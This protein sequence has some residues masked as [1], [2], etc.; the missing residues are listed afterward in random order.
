MAMPKRTPDRVVPNGSLAGAAPES[1]EGPA[2]IGVRTR[3]M[4]DDCRPDGV[5][6]SALDGTPTRTGVGASIT[7]I[8]AT[9]DAGPDVSHPVA[10]WADW[11]IVGTRYEN[12]AV[13]SRERGCDCVPRSTLMAHRVRRK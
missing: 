2:D 8:P 9:P 5:A 3:P 7:G 10:D 1:P 6:G 13:E 11:T 12:M 4:F